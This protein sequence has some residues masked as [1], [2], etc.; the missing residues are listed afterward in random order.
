MLAE[1]G[2]SFLGLGVQPP[3]ASWGDG[4]RA[5]RFLNQSPTLVIF[6]GVAIVLAVLA[7]NVLGDGLRDSVGREIR[8]GA[9]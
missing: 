5:Y 7:F 1:A 2:L 9:S 8:R 4:G 6:P 3:D